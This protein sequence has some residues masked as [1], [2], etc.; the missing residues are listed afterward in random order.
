MENQRCPGRCSG[1]GRA[2][3]C[4]TVALEGTARPQVLSKV[5]VTSLAL[6]TWGTCAQ[7]R[8]VVCRLESLGSVHQQ[9]GGGTSLFCQRQ[10]PGRPVWQRPGPAISA[11]QD[12]DGARSHLPGNGTQLQQLAATGAELLSDVNT[13]DVLCDQNNKFS[14]RFAP[15]H[16]TAPGPR[17]RVAPSGPF[18]GSSSCPS[19]SVLPP[20]RSTK[21]RPLV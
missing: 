13:S 19:Q 20:S 6:I 18:L 7:G 3:V 2:L 5:P 12:L 16:T 1:P 21:V 17:A 9:Q 14:S 4:Q 11:E 10:Q 8:G 15:P